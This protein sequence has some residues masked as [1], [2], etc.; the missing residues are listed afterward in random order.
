MSKLTS[1]LNNAAV[2]FGLAD[3]KIQNFSANCVH[4]LAVL[5]AQEHGIIRTIVPVEVDLILGQLVSQESHERRIPR[6]LAMDGTRPLTLV[7]SKNCASKSA[8]L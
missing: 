7:A 2:V 3:C 1:T 5:G 6:Y 4:M 8:A